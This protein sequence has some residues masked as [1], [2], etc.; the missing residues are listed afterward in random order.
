M[1]LTLKTKLIYFLGYIKGIKT[2]FGLNP[3][4]LLD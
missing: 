4:F 3:N 1:T 2:I